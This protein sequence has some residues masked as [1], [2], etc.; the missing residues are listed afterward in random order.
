M[1][2][3]TTCALCN[4]SHGDYQHI[5]KDCPFSPSIWI[6]ITVKFRISHYN[7]TSWIM[8]MQEFISFCDSSKEDSMILAKLCVASF[9]WSIRKERNNRTFK[10]ESRTWELVLKDILLQDHSCV[11]FLRLNVSSFIFAAWNLPIFELQHSFSAVQGKGRKWNLLILIK[12]N[13][14]LGIFRN[15]DGYVM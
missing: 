9:A 7:Y 12:S 11:V 15:E 13:S 10:G 6:E 14:A 3:D 5:F 8:H 1:I 2:T 4:G